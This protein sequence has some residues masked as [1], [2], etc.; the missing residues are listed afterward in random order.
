MFKSLKQLNADW[1]AAMARQE[2]KKNLVEE[3]SSKDL[4][5]SFN[6]Q[7]RNKF[8]T[9]ADDDKDEIYTKTYRANN[10]NEKYYGIPI[11]SIDGG[12]T[13]K[14]VNP[15]KEWMEAEIDIDGLFTMLTKEG[16]AVSGWMKDGQ[17]DMEHFDKINIALVD[18]DDT[19]TV[20]LDNLEDHEFYQKYCSGWYTTP[21][22]TSEAHRFRL[23]FI[24]ERTITKELDIR[25]I[26]TQLIKIFGGDVNCKDGS[27]IFFGSVGAQKKIVY[28]KQIPNNIIDELIEDGTV[29][30]EQYQ[31]EH[32]NYDNDETKE[33]LLNLLRNASVNSY[34]A[35][36]K[37][38]SAM[39]SAGY[40]YADL[41]YVSANNPNHSSGK[42]KD[43]NATNMKKW[44]DSFNKPSARKISPGYLWNLVGGYP[45]ELKKPREEESDTELQ[46]AIAKMS[47]REPIIVME[48]DNV[49]YDQIPIKSATSIAE[50]YAVKTRYKG[51]GAATGGGKSWEMVKSIIELSKLDGEAKREP[52]LLDYAE[53]QSKMKTDT[54]QQAIIVVPTLVAINTILQYFWLQLRI[55]GNIDGD[56]ARSMGIYPVTAETN[57]IEVPDDY[58][59]IITTA[60]YVLPKGDSN[61]YY[62]FMHHFQNN[63]HVFIDEADNFIDSAT[64]TIN[65]GARYVNK[66]HA[67]IPYGKC[68]NRTGAKNACDSCVYHPDAYR[69]SFNSF[70]LPS[71]MLRSDKEVDV[72]YEGVFVPVEHLAGTIIREE[73]IWDTTNVKFLE[74]T[75]LPRT[76]N[77]N[78]DGTPDEGAESLECSFNEWVDHS[79]ALCW[80]PVIMTEMPIDNATG[81]F[82]D[83]DWIMNSEYNDKLDDNTR[84]GNIT[85]PYNAC[86]VPKFVGVSREPLAYIAQHCASLTLLT[87]TM[88]DAHRQFIKDCG[89]DMQYYQAPTA[90]DQMM[91]K[92]NLILVD[93][94]RASQGDD[95]ADK[96]YMKSIIQNLEHKGKPMLVF[97]KDK[98]SAKWLYKSLVNKVKDKTMMSYNKDNLMLTDSSDVVM[99]TNDKHDQK[100]GVIYPRSPIARG[101]NMGEFKIALLAG[102]P[103]PPLGFCS[104]GTTEQLLYNILENRIGIVVQ[105]E[106]RIMRREEGEVFAERW[107]I[108]DVGGMHLNFHEGK[109][110]PK[111][112]DIFSKIF[113]E[114]LSTIAKDVVVVSLFGSDYRFVVD[115]LNSIIRGG[116]RMNYVVMVSDDMTKHD[117]NTK[118]EFSDFY[119]KAKASILNKVPE[120]KRIMDARFKDYR[121]KLKVNEFKE[122]LENGENYKELWKN[123]NITRLNST[124]KELIRTFKSIG[125]V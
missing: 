1:D 19:V 89:I 34:D 122:R 91:D 120:I 69:Y 84:R 27:R 44:W 13:Y 85:F 82:V 79:R 22:H 14:I 59:V 39:V 60:A 94:H 80:R 12:K 109:L 15:G 17:R 114:P 103:L 56:I 107:I 81:N 98:R 31:P 16:A 75:N 47:V 121:E 45:D 24:L 115:E 71:L 63:P 5:F 35:W 52:D 125:S 113:F 29:E 2:A 66:N 96:N 38:L 54:F 83:R 102:D 108:V 72:K 67:L 23:V 119:G 8:L 28:D 95:M 41:C 111:D 48:E 61:Y 106:G 50:A 101:Q 124:N 33:V 70:L 25:A 104:G 93:S 117:I 118:K 30:E 76:I 90:D 36:W 46:D 3:A 112:N 37:M 100:V 11:G 73:V 9:P 43:K 116:E 68:N 26:Y 10:L 51:I 6:A 42:F 32:V 74:E 78:I 55:D 18:I 77:I 49:I 110:A 57:H 21:S 97:E 20:T 87:A 86:N 64:I 62:S 7:W 99:K 53:E 88:G 123:M 105:C 92:V 65:L 58:R 4:Y 40:T